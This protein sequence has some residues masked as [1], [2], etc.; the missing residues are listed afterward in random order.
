MS[1]D[2]SDTELFCVAP[3]CEHRSPEILPGEPRYQVD[4]EGISG[5][6]HAE[7]LIAWNR[8]RKEGTS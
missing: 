8:V 6:V 2:A 7:C 3:A 5:P 4:M 1:D